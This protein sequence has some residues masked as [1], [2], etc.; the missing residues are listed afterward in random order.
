MAIDLNGVAVSVVRGSLSGRLQF[1]D[2]IRRAQGRQGED[3]AWQSEKLG[4]RFSAEAS[5]GI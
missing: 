1:L 2:T 5:D 3:G 4:D